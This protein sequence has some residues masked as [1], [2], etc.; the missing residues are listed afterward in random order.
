MRRARADARFLSKSV[1][2]DA[3]GRITQEGDD[4]DDDDDNV[5]VAS[6]PPPPVPPRPSPLKSL[7]NEGA[8]MNRSASL[9]A[10]TDE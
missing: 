3:F 10:I 4:D 6:L 8:A 7:S 2:I 1:S 5:S 9:Q